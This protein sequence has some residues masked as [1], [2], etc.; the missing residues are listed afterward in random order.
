MAK[1]MSDSDMGSMFVRS[2]HFVEIQAGTERA[3]PPTHV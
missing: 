3:L 1:A 2:N